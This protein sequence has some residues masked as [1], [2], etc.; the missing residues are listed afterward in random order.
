M[1]K[2]CVITS[3]MGLIYTGCADEESQVKDPVATTAESTEGVKDEKQAADKSAEDSIEATAQAP[4]TND[5][6]SAPASIEGQA[7]PEAPA[8]TEASSAGS[9]YVNVSLL[10][11]RS[12]PSM[13]APVV[14]VLGQGSEV[15]DLGREN[16][17]W[18]KIEDGKYVS[19]KYLGTTK[20]AV[21]PDPISA[22]PEVATE[23]IDQGST[24]AAVEDTNE[25]ASEETTTKN[26]ETPNTKAA[27]SE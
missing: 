12:G 3:T 4:T 8:K 7:S 13:G 5:E 25:T 2:I 22:E 27:P 10:N 19:S 26:V 15:A 20:D 1:L 16:Q 9:L 23:T 11:V 24:N 14:D 18:V 6:A 17:I 21:I